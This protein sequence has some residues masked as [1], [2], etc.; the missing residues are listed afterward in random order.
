MN[1]YKKLLFII[2]PNAGMRKKE[3]PLSE[4]IMIFSDFGYESIV[5][6]TQKSGDGETL[7]LEHASEEI[8]LIVCMGGDGT[9]N[10]TFSGASKLGWDK[11]IGYIP[12]GSTNDFAASLGLPNNP[13]EAARYIMEHE[14][15]Y[16]DLGE[17]NGRRFVYVACCGIFTKASY[18]TPQEVK[19]ALGHFAYLL[20]GVKDLG[21]IHPITMKIDIGSEVLQDNYIF[22]AICNTHSLGGVMTLDDSKIS[23]NDGAF[24]LFTIAKP[25]DLLQLSSIIIALKN[26]KY[27]EVTDL[28]CFR[29]I[30]KAEIIFP[31]FEDWSLDGERGEGREKCRFKVIHNAVRLIY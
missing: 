22:V 10:E 1:I 9:L 17:F 28:V 16:L 14:A 25:R 5:C 24:E 18:E 13:V 11:P 27:E 8:D 7:V 23:L 31:Q 15:K 12:A 19:N 2:N 3:S 26:Q 21:Q 29:P 4:I 30:E 20:E 6:F